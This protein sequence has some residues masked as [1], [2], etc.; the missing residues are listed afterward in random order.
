MSY[1]LQSTT[2]SVRTRIHRMRAAQHHTA[3]QKLA[4]GKFIVRP[5]RPLPFTEEYLRAHFQEIHKAWKEGKLE[6]R[7]QVG[8]KLVD[9]DTMQAAA[10]VTT[11]PLPTPPLDTAANDRGPVGEKMRPYIDGRAQ[12]EEAPVPSL[13]A[14]PVAEV[15]E[16][17]DEEKEDD[18]EETDEDSEGDE[19]SDEPDEAAPET[20]PTEPPPVALEDP[21]ERR[22]RERDGEK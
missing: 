2:R 17:D 13:L 20:A 5:S 22:R 8:R 11:P 6:V 10:L 12:T 18:E 16:G 14:T 19:E 1:F 9:L 3:V 4:G 21:A 7:T 15:D